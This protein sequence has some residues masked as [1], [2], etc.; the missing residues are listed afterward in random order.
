MSP[1]IICPLPL[2]GPTPSPSHNGTYFLYPHLFLG[3]T[4]LFPPFQHSPTVTHSSVS[5]PF[6]SICTFPYHLFSFKTIHSQSITLTKIIQ[7]CKFETFIIKILFL[8]IPL[9]TS[10]FAGNEHL[11]IG[12][13]SNPSIAIEWRRNWRR[14]RWKSESRPAARTRPHVFIYSRSR[15][16]FP[17][18]RVPIKIANDDKCRY[19]HG[20]LIKGRLF[21]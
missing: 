14:N 10:Y 11:G 8:H 6:F 7:S 19:P 20:R 21:Y 2:I 3:S 12:N 13:N 16:A 17:M 5:V 1:A 4:H 9:R 18:A 15:N